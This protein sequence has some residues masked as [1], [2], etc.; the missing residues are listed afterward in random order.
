MPWPLGR[1]TAFRL[2]F[3]ALAAVVAARDVCVMHTYFDPSVLASD[4]PD[5]VFGAWATI[6]AWRTAWEQAGWQTRVLN[7]SDARLHPHYDELKSKLASLP[8]V[9]PKGYD[10]ACFLRHVAMAAVCCLASQ[11]SLTILYRSL[12][13][14]QRV[15]HFCVYPG[16]S[17]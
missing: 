13:T 10:L 3:L 11:R 16:A 1:H 6:A 14:S 2:S 8:T 4:G 12:N 15:A 5:S 17:L 7:E 9:N